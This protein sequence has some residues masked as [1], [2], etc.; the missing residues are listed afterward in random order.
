MFKVWPVGAGESDEPRE[1]FE[2]RTGVCCTVGPEEPH[3]IQ[4]NEDG[5]VLTYL[6][7]V[8]PEPAK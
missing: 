5:L 4:A 1:V 2:P 3:E 7:L 8:A 6:G